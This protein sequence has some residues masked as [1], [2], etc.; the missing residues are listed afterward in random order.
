MKEVDSKKMWLEGYAVSEFLPHNTIDCVILGYGNHSLKV[1]VLKWKR[2]ELWSLPGGYVLRSESFDQAA[3]RILK[4]RTGLSSIFLKQFYTFSDP[5][6]NR[7]KY[8]HETEIIKQ[9]LQNADLVNGDRDMDWFTKRFITTGYF[10]LVNMQKTTP[11]PDFLSDRCEW[12]SLQE[13]PDLLADH[14]QLLQKALETL[15]IQLNYLPV[16]I[17]LLPKRFTMK[18]LRLLY[19]AILKT[20]LERSNFQRKMLKLGIL[21]RHEKQMTGAANKAP[22]LYSFD[23]EKYAALIKKGTGFYFD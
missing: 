8:S 4:Q 12:K 1:L 2:G 6:R 20:N 23:R 5:G 13:V 14:N 22:Y 19:E 9:I 10:A 15:K 17:S 21:V 7:P 16:G 11:S 3:T 18:D